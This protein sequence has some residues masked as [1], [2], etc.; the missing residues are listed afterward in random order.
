MTD[1]TIL[2]GAEPLFFPG[3]DIGVLLS[4]HP[5]PDTRQAETP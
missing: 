2:Q 4:P 3:N 5:L 1:E